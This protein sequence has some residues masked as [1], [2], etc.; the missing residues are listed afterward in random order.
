M[1]AKAA[2]FRSRFQEKYGDVCCRV[3]LGYDVSTQEGMQAA[4][5]SGRIMDFCPQ[6]AQY[7]I[8][9]LKEIL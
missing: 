8:E 5:D 4:L 9:I 7:A 6:M 2:Q 1:A 3:L